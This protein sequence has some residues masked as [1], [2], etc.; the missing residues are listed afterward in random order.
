MIFVD[1]YFCLQTRFFGF[2]ELIESNQLYGGALEEVKAHRNVL[3]VLT[4]NRITD[5][6]RGGFTNRFPKTQC[7]I[8]LIFSRI[9]VEPRRRVKKKKNK[10]NDK[11]QISSGHNS[12]WLLWLFFFFLSFGFRTRFFGFRETTWLVK[13]NKVT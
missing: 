7:I 2:C 11:N 3:W 6:V 12:H 9:R 5:V 13:S 8:V 10:K 4:I 1:F